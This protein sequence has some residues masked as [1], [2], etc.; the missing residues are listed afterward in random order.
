MEKRRNILIA[1]PEIP[2]E[3]RSRVEGREI[4]SV[5]R[6]ERRKLKRPYRRYEPLLM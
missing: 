2:Y 1:K 6:P 5:V 3:R 4:V